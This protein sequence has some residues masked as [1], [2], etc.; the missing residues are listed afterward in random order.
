MSET[1]IRDW[2]LPRLQ[3]LV[4]EAIAAG[5]DPAAVTAVITEIIDGTDLA[6]VGPTD[7]MPSAEPS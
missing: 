5:F 4:N 1:P 3:R 2:V 6:H 7:P